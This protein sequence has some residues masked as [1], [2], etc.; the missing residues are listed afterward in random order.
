M[1]FYR[2]VIMLLN[3]TIMR[4]GLCGA[5]PTHDSA[6]IIH[7]VDYADFG[8]HCSETM[9][10]AFEIG[11]GTLT[12]TVPAIVPATVLVNDCFD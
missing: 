3:V 1:Q 7:L 10:K 12:A 8:Y 2:F 5:A 4:A 9:P 11:A 6:I